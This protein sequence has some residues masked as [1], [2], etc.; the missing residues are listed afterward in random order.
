MSWQ[1]IVVAALFCA[2]I[3]AAIAQHK[4]LDMP[5]SFALGALLGVLGIII[6]LIRKPGLPK[7]PA[8]MRAVQCPR[9]N[10]VL[11]IPRDDTSYDCYQCH[12]RFHG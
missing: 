3:S 6:V 7:A 8:G 12:D 11:N 2:V 1:T 5:K 4:N 9:C 10:T